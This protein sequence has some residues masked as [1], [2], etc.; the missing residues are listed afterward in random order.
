M[1]K[2]IVVIF[3]TFS[4][5]TTLS[6][7]SIDTKKSVVNFTTT[8]LLVNTVEGTFS[9][10]KGDLKF[11]AKNLS[12]SKFDVCVDASSLNTENEKR[13]NHLKN[14]DFFEVEKY[15]KICFVSTSIERTESGFKTTGNLTMHGVT[16][17]IEIPFTFDNN[18]FTGKL[19]INRLD[20]NI[21][22]DYSN[23]TA[24]KEAELEIIC[25]LK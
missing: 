7:Q 16:K 4:I 9:G 19:E 25:V 2:Q 6:A 1:I 20:F 22:G 11:N 24:S 15:P 13:D 5:F 10:M 21:G 8:A 14:K 18:T 23:F 3:L 12:A 17:Q